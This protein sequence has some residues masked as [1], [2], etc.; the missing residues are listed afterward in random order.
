M[1]RLGQSYAHPLIVLL[2]HPNDLEI[3]RF[4]TAAS[5]AV[6]GAVQRNRAK[7]RIRAAFQQYMDQIR[8]GWDIFIIARK[9]IHQASFDELTAGLEN[10]LQRADLLY[11]A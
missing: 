9:P 2:A 5:K 8:S 3:S 6:G 10:L 11:A 7:R 4:G 1:R